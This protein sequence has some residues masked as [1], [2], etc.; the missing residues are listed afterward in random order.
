M[1]D[2]VITLDVLWEDIYGKCYLVVWQSSTYKIVKVLKLFKR[3]PQMILGDFLMTII[4]YFSN[5]NI[6]I[7]FFFRSL[8][9]LGP[10]EATSFL[11]SGSHYLI[12][13]QFFS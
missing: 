5:I 6:V 4:I 13:R 9:C 10:R 8:Y 2:D 1:T 11:G 3:L 7:F 12:G